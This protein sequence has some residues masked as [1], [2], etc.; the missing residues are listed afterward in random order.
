MSVFW[1][2]EGVPHTR[3][4]SDLTLKM[5]GSRE[6]HTLHDT[7][8]PGTIP[9]AKAAEIGVLLEF[10]VY[11]AGAY[12]EHLWEADMLQA[13]GQAL[14][15]L[16]NLFRSEEEVFSTAAQQRVIECTQRALLLAKR[17][18]ILFT[19]KHHMLAH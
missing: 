15:D 3:R 6:G 7:R 14:S 8:H 10:A 5:L 11:L 1:A 17:L 12:K 16:L 19:P 9:K 2:N 18:F 13:A 4:L